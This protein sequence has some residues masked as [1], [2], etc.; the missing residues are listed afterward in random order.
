MSEEEIKMSKGLTRREL[1]KQR[2]RE[3]LTKPSDI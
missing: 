2:I 3:Y 1:R